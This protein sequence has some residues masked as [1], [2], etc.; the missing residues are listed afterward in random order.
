MEGTTW[1]MPCVPQFDPL[2]WL[3]EEG[4]ESSEGFSNW[5]LESPSPPHPDPGED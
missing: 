4:E 1:P 3:E 2:V 5:G